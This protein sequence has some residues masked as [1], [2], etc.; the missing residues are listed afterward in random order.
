[1]LLGEGSDRKYLCASQ[2][3]EVPRKCRVIRGTSGFEIPLDVHVES[4]G[5]I[6][7]A[8]GQQLGPTTVECRCSARCIVWNQHTQPWGVCFIGCGN[9][10]V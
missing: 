6:S 2:N 4:L 1:V 9:Q 8:A 7:R 3:R 10:A 5:S